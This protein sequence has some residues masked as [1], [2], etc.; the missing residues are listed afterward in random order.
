MGGFFCTGL[1]LVHF[2]GEEF[3]LIVTSHFYPISRL[4]FAY[5]QRVVLGNV[6][7]CIC[8]PII[9]LHIDYILRVICGLKNATEKRWKCVGKE[10]LHLDH[11]LYTNVFN[12][13][14]TFL[15][16]SGRC[17]GGSKNATE[18]RWECFE[19][20]GLHLD[21]FQYKN[22]SNMMP[23]FLT[24][25]EGVLGYRKMR[26]ENG[27]NAF[28]NRGCIWTIFNTRMYSI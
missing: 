28:E 5:F 22:V 16:P 12:M 15:T 4:Q 8:E 25:P 2:L 9:S 7:F 21:H 1:N 24:P 11:L 14:P 6:L 20:Q 18:K 19:K 23:T 13:I 10:G 17:F 26:R 27:G 3:V